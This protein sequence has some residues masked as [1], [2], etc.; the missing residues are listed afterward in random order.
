MAAMAAANLVLLA[1]LFPGVTVA[2]HTI[3]SAPN[4][5]RAWDGRCKRWMQG[6]HGTESWRGSGWEKARGYFPQLDNIVVAI[7]IVERICL[8]AG[9]WV[10]GIQLLEMLRTRLSRAC[11]C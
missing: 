2:C 3:L 1:I 10:I 5:C 9:L 6:K 11:C 4:S 8:H 7:T